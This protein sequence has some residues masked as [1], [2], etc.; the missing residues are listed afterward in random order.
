[1]AWRWGS[2]GRARARASGSPPFPWVRR[3]RAAERIPSSSPL[4][5]PAPYPSPSQ[6]SESIK[7]T[8]P[9][10]MEASW[11]RKYTYLDTVGVLWGVA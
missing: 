7:Y 9:F 8:L 5:S 10:D 4:R 6:G 11:D 3:P 1:M 2:L